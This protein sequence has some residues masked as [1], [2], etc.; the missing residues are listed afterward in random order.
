MLHQDRVTFRFRLLAGAQE[1]RVL[2]AALWLVPLNGIVY[3]SW[4]SC[5]IALV[6]LL[7]QEDLTWNNRYP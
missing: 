7:V 5:L 3:W 1:I 4:W 2:P 6:R